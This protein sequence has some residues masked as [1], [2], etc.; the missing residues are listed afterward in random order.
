MAFRRLTARYLSR[1]PT[2]TDGWMGASRT[3]PSA[4][5]Y[6]R[7]VNDQVLEFVQQEGDLRDTETQ[8]KW[9]LFGR[10]IDGPLKGHQ[11]APIDGGVHF[12]FAWLAFHPDS[13][14]YTPRDEKYR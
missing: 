7:H 9:D 4:A 6:S 1:T 12:A 2:P 3:T 13:S 14:M 8:T 5:A 10:A 11:L